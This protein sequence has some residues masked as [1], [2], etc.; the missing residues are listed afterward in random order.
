MTP[1]WPRIRYALALLA[2]CAIATCPM[3]R[4]SCTARRQARE[5]ENLLDYLADRVAAIVA[6]TGKV[7]PEAAGPTP[8]PTC[9]EQGGTCSADPALWSAAGWRALDFSIDG[10]FRYT[11]EYAPDPSGESAVLRAT[12][13]LDCNGTSSFYELHVVVQGKTPGKEAAGFTPAAGIER[14]WTKKDPYE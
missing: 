5:A 3:A 7:P 9:C 2:L 11:Y 6:T 1:W 4:R 13:D 12:G 10:D 14:T 8:R